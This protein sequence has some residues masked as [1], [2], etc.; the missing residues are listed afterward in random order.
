MFDAG[1]LVLF[2][3]AAL[4]KQNASLV[5]LTV[6]PAYAGLALATNQV[7]TEAETGIV[8]AA[9]A[10]RLGPNKAPQVSVGAPTSTSYLRILGVPL[11]RDGYPITIHDVRRA[12]DA[13]PATRLA[14]PAREPRIVR[15]S[16]MST[17]CSVYF[18]IQDS[19]S[20][21]LARDI[22]ACNRIMINGAAAT[23]T[24]AEIC[25]GVPL[26][27]RCWRWG[28]PTVACKVRL[29]TCPICSGPHSREEHHSNAGC[30]KPNSKLTPP[31]LGTPAGEPC[32]HRAHCPNCL[33]NHSADSRSCPYWSH[34][35]DSEWIAARYSKVRARMRSPHLSN[36]P[37]S[38]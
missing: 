8:A 14:T 24:A 7:P 23:I 12:L 1:A 16:R 19:K 21:K 33:G 13:H 26:C 3:N 35:F 6:S 20:G 29:R 34:R 28:H 25:R 32:P 36:P 15:E 5:V 37:L 38:G 11:F 9:I 2:I 4:R 17:S 10:E 31:S 18:D 30:C 22:L 27:Q